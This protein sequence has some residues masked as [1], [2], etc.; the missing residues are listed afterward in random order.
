MIYADFQKLDDMGRLVLSC[1]GS[2]KDLDRQNFD[3]TAATDVI[4]YS[5]DMDENGNDNW[6][7]VEGSV[8]FDEEAA[9]WLGNYDSS[10]FYHSSISS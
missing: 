2:L 6:L 3:L 9:T 5:D 8:L 1:I 7:C 10:N 4:F